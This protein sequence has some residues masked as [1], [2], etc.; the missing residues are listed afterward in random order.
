MKS[1]T[2]ASRSQS[3]GNT[4]KNRISRTTSSNKKNNVEDH[5]TSVKSSS[6]KKNRV[7]EPAYG[8]HYCL[9]TATWR[10]HPIGMK[11]YATWDWGTG[12]HGVLGECIGTVPV[13]LENSGKLDHEARSARLAAAFDDRPNEGLCH[14]GLGYRGTWGVGVMYW[15]CSGEVGCTGGC[16]GRE[17]LFGGNFCG[18]HRPLV[19]FLRSKD[20]VPEFIIKFLKTIQV[21]LNVTVR[22]IRTNNGTKFINQ[23]L[24]NYHK[25]VRI[26]HETSVASSCHSLLHLELIPDTCYPT[27]DKKLDLTY[28]HIFGALCYPTIDSEDLRKLKPKTDIGIFVGYALAK[29]AYQIYNRHTRRIMETV[30]VDFDELITMAFEQFGSRPKPQLMNPGKISSGLV[31]KPPSPTPHIPLIR[32]FILAG[33]CGLRSWEWC[34]GGGVECRVGER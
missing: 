31:Q 10:A 24:R 8:E 15:Y 25:D 7:S 22:K 34:E 18:P 27:I 17:E 29:K 28:F 16:C 32:S 33:K 12:E 11:G 6:N 20:E 19:K 23:T 4:K 3:L 9:I 26:S 21:R 2:S 1:S 30:H 13:R 14:V 5:P